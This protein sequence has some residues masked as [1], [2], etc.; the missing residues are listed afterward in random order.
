[1]TRTKSTYLAIVAILLSPMAAN[2]DLIMVIDN[3]GGF[4][5]FSL[6]GSDTVVSGTSN[7]NG[8]WLFEALAVS[9][10]NTSLDQPFQL[11]SGSGSL[12]TT[13]AGTLGIFDVYAGSGRTSCCHFG[14]RSTGGMQMVAGDLV[15]WS[16]MF[17][18]NMSF[19]VLN[20]G[21]YDF[22]QLT[23][24]DYEAA[25]LDGG[26]QIRIGQVPEPGTLALLGI[27]LFGLGL[28]TRRKQ[29]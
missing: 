12:S 15:S 9:M 7:T 6:S 3:D 19:S 14:V 10:F 4:A 18:T 21:I 27:G 17:T 5:R 23:A 28:A 2:A 29:A 1:M 8:F 11:T 22:G 20:A 16:G 13:T 26:L 24:Y 25:I